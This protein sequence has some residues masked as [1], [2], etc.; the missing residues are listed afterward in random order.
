MDAVSLFISEQPESHRRMLLRLRQ[1]LLAAGPHHLEERL[2]YN[3]PFYYYYGR[4]CYLNPH[5]SGVDLGFCRGSKLSNEQ[6]LLGEKGRVA[7]RSITYRTEAEIDEPALREMVQEALLLN[8]LQYN[9]G[10]K[11]R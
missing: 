8:E 1:M 10:K 5:R 11:N 6:G 3:I 9:S 7:V 2:S 4:L